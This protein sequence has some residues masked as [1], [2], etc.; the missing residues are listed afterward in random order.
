MYLIYVDESGDT[1]F[2][3]GSTRYFALSA[4]V[5]HEL[6]WHQVLDSTI[7]LRRDLRTAYGLKLREEIHAAHLIHKPGELARIPKSLRLRLMRDVLDFESQLADVGVINIL[8]DKSGK[9]PDYDVFDNAWRALVQR[10]DN[11][12]SH[13][14]FP[15]P[16]NPEDRGILIVDQTDE[17]KLRALTRRMRVYNPVP[18]QG[19]DG[20]RQLPIVSL[21]EDAVHRDSRH[22]YLIQMA[23][24]NAYF[25][26][27]KQ[28]PGGY[29]RRKGARNFFDRLD[30]VLCKVASATDPQGIVR[31]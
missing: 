16:Q 10:F 9:T 14:N 3:A 15:G 7:T 18:Y 1:G 30:P 12:L 20:Y 21:V 25:L 31:L 26:F 22:S 17:L 19:G 5:V 29:V 24:V 8:V 2:L 6:R 27:Q 13:H 28:L 23:D 4:L 11:T